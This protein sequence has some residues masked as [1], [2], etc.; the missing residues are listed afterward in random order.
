MR[1]VVSLAVAV[2]RRPAGWLPVLAVVAFAQSFG[3]SDMPV[4]WVAHIGGFVAGIVLFPLF[5]RPPRPPA[6][7]TY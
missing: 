5:D 7:G 3:L 2:L 4:A 1:H 6:T